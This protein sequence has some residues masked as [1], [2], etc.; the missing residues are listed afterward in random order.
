MGVD[1]ILGIHQIDLT[2]DACLQ[3]FISAALI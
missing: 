2:H 1:L 3:G